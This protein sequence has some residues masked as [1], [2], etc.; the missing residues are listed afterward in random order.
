MGYEPEDHNDQIEQ[1]LA[2]GHATADQTIVIDGRRAWATAAA[3]S[4]P[5]GQGPR[6]LFQQVPEATV[7]RERVGKPAG[8]RIHLDVRVGD[9]ERDA[10]VERL[11][12]LGAVRLWDGEQGPHRWVTMADPEGNVFCV[13]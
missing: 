4:D 10:E 3:S 11:V 7:P 12:G 2:A 5:A 1:L 9:D 8:Q 13:A 6:L